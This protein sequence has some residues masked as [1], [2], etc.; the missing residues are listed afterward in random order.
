MPGEIICF[1]YETRVETGCHIHRST[2][3]LF[4]SI[5]TYEAHT[6]CKTLCSETKGSSTRGLVYKLEKFLGPRGL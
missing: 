2:Y 3:S 4:Y 5:N 1:P 6:M